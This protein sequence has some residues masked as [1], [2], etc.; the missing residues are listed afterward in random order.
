[1]LYFFVQKNGGNMAK[2][3]F[4]T[5]DS[6]LHVA[7]NSGNEEMIELLLST[8]ARQDF[9]NHLNRSGQSVLQMAAR[10]DMSSLVNRLLI[11]GASPVLE[12]AAGFKPISSADS[13][14]QTIQL[15]LDKAKRQRTRRVFSLL[16]VCH[17]EVDHS[18][19][20]LKSKDQAKTSQ[21]LSQ[22]LSSMSLSFA[23]G[24]G[25]SKEKMSK[26]FATTSF[27]LALDGR[28]QPSQNN[29]TSSIS[30]KPTAEYA[31]SIGSDDSSDLQHRLSIEVPTTI[32]IFDFYLFDFNGEPLLT[33][34]V[35]Q[36]SVELVEELL[37]Q[38]E[39]LAK[40]F[41]KAASRRVFDFGMETSQ[42][43]NRSN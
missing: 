17:E 37:I 40:E 15:R 8:N 6:L 38:Y 42:E 26:A 14:S 10:K 20:Q 33:A 30:V 32:N 41:K 29:L 9:L 28:Q 31:S 43:H 34:T 12:E 1:M 11:L 7:I 39:S 3:H 25:K 35:R 21:Q 13:I 24:L 19:P 16:K 4:V 23:R 22:L 5:G 18:G 2:E 36:Q 27:S